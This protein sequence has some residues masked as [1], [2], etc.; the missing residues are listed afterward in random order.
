MLIKSCLLLLFK[1]TNQEMKFKGPND[2]LI[3][4]TFTTTPSEKYK[5]L[6]LNPSL[7]TSYIYLKKVTIWNGEKT[8]SLS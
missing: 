2:L 7:K 8:G 3:K 1:N 4:D 5:Y 6:G